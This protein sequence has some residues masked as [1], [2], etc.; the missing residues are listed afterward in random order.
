MFHTSNLICHDKSVIREIIFFPV[1]EMALSEIQIEQVSCVSV[2]FSFFFIGMI[3]GLLPSLI[4]LTYYILKR[5]KPTI[6]GSPHYIMAEQ[7]TYISVPTKDQLPK[8]H[9]SVGTSLY[10]NGTS[11]AKYFA[12]DFE[13]P[14]TLKRQ[15][16]EVRNGHSRQDSDNYL[17]S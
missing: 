4:Y 13:I 6:P 2:G 17:Y 7:N 11:K 15:S 3:I 5:R 12:D 16:H 8:K 1:S 9:S 10:P 14:T